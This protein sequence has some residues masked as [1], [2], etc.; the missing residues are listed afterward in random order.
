MKRLSRP[1]I[2]F[3]EL[4]L[5]HEQPIKTTC[6]RVLD[7][8]LLNHNHHAPLDLNEICKEA[9]TDRSYSSMYVSTNIWLVSAY[10]ENPTWPEQVSFGQKTKNKQQVL[11]YSTMP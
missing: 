1:R 4:V 10:P 5:H 2:E 11:A 9:I 8:Q 7:L 3:L 6:K